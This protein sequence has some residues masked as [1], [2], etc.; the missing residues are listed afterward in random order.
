M[1]CSLAE[2]LWSAFE[3]CREYSNAQYREKRL[4]EEE[5]ERFYQG[6]FFQKLFPPTQNILRH[7]REAGFLRPPQVEFNRSGGRANCTP[8]LLL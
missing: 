6:E 8:R 3:Q 4:L 5:N 2:A 1:N 7:I